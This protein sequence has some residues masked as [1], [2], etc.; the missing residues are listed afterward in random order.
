MGFGIRNRWVPKSERGRK[1]ARFLRARGYDIRNKEVCGRYVCNLPMFTEL[2]RDELGDIAA[3]LDPQ[4][5]YDKWWNAKDLAA[6]IRK[7]PRAYGYVAQDIAEKAANRIER[8]WM[9]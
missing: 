3:I 7:D 6:S 2:T 1:V 9:L 4:R 5:A 8:D